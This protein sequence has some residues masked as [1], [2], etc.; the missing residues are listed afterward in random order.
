[1]RSRKEKEEYQ[2]IKGVVSF[3]WKYS[4]RRHTEAEIAA[5]FHTTE[6]TLRR[7]IKNH[8][9][10]GLPYLRNSIRILKIFYVAG[11]SI[12]TDIYELAARAGF[13]DERSFRRCWDTL[14]EIPL[15]KLDH[16]INQPQKVLKKDVRVLLYNALRHLDQKEVSVF[17]SKILSENGL[18]SFS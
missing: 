12:H 4:N 3:L 18:R 2:L 7:K 9:H 1:M 14:C 10:T 8:F 11:G 16:Q 13:S 15:H 17:L 6:K 5:R